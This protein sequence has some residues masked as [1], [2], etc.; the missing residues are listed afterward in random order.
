MLVTSRT[1]SGFT[2]SG[3]LAIP[4]GVTRPKGSLALRL[5]SSLFQAPTTGSPRSPLSRLHGERASAM[6]STFQLSRST[7]LYLTHRIALITLMEKGIAMVT[8]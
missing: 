7:E 6:V 3:R 8:N 4:T 2:K 1:I 5:T